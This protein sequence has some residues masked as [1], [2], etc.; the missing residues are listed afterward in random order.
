[1]AAGLRLHIHLMCLSVNLG[2]GSH[3]KGLWDKPRPRAKISNAP[4]SAALRGSGGGEVKD[5]V[6][7]QSRPYAS[8]LRSSVVKEA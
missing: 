7:R 4:Y 5:P 2:G 6:P 3:R 1:M 8:H